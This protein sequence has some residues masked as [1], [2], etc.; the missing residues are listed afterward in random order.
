MGMSGI[1][2]SGF[3]LRRETV[4]TFLN[5]GEVTPL[6]KVCDMASDL[7]VVGWPVAIACFAQMRGGQLD[8]SAHG[9]IDFLIRGS[10]AASFVC[11]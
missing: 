11:F 9:L 3:T 6:A 10:S 7:V 1:P 2:D 8:V 4:H 5:E